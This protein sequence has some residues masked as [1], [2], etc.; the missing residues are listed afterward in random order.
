MKINFAINNKKNNNELNFD[1][2]SSNKSNIKNNIRRNESKKMDTF[3]NIIKN[4]EN[5]KVKN[6]PLDLIIN[7]VKTEDLKINEGKE[8][9]KKDNKISEQKKEKTNFC[10]YFIYKILCGKKYEN[11]KVYEDFRKK[12]MSE[13]QLYQNYFY[14]NELISEKQSE[15]S[16]PS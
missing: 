15:N 9:D 10:K 6:N 5:D 14:I 12:I 4:K 2:N 13:E 3:F 1:N 7:N 16:I 8:N 11:I